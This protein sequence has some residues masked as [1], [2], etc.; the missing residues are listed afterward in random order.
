MKYLN[1]LVMH[2]FHYKYKKIATDGFRVSG[3][4]RVN[5]DIFEDFHFGASEKE[6]AGQN[7]PDEVVLLSQTGTKILFAVAIDSIRNSP[8]VS[9]PSTSRSIEDT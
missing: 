4:Y 2:M 3:S 1:S 6:A 7:N 9:T 8:T 5:R